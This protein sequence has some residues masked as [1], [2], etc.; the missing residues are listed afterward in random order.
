MRL[1]PSRLLAFLVFVAGCPDPGDAPSGGTE[2]HD[3]I[4]TGI[5][6]TSGGDHGGP[7]VLPDG[8][9]DGVDETGEEKLDAGMLD[10]PHD[11]TEWQYHSTSGIYYRSPTAD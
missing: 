8:D 3:C 7:F 11:P 9:D 10:G 1:P 2:G 4:T 6:A 5:V